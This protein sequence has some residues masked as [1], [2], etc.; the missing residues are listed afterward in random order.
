MYSKL[1]ELF[2]KAEGGVL[3]SKGCGGGDVLDELEAV[4]GAVEVVSPG[5]GAAAG[6]GEID[7]EVGGFAAGADGAFDAEVLAGGGVEEEAGVGG[8][9]R[10]GDQDGGGGGAGGGLQGGERGG[11][12]K[13]SGNEIVTGHEGTP[14][15]QKP[16]GMRLSRKIPSL[17]PRYAR[18]KMMGRFRGPRGV[19]GGRKMVAP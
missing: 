10:G 5:V 4:F 11:G 18:G 6:G 8:G 9:G 19:G 17:F 7:D 2:A 3:E 12:E 13:K 16:L 14:K 15:A 1:S